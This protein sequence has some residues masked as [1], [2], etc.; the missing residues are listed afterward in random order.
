MVSS[1]HTAP[2]L[3]QSSFS[4]SHIYLQLGIYL[5]GFLLLIALHLLASYLIEKLNQQTINEQ[6]RLRIGEII[7]TDLIRIESSAYQMATLRS[8]RGQTVVRRAIS[9]QI[10]ELRNA[11]QILEQGGTLKRVTELNIESHERM[12]KTV[13]Y[14]PIKRDSRYVLEVID[15]LPKLDQ[16]ELMMDELA[17]RLRNRNRQ[18]DSP[19]REDYVK[20]TLRTKDYLLT[21][22]PLFTRMKENA[23]RLFFESQQRLMQLEKDISTRK[24][25]YGLIEWLLVAFIIF[26]VLI[27]G[28]LMQRQIARANHRLQQITEQMIIA[29]HE[30][31]AANQA[32]SNFLAN[33]SHEIRT[34]MNGVVGMLQLLSK[35]ELDERQHHYV[36]TALRSA[37]LQTTIINDILDF[38]K[39]EADRLALESIKFDLYE[40]VEE[41]ATIL[42]DG[43]YDKGV[44]L[45]TFIDPALPQFIQGDPTRLRQLLVNLI[46]NAI[47]F[48]FVGEINV[49]VQK[50]HERTI[51][52]QIIDTGIGMESETRQRLFQPFTQAD[53]STTRRFGGT[54]LGLAISYQLVKAM[55][56]RIGVESTL[57]QG[58]TFWFSVPLIPAVQDRSI[59]AVDLTQHRMLVVDD[60]ATNREVISS[61]LDAWKVA[62]CCVANPADALAIY[63]EGKEKQ[64]NFSIVLLDMH[65]P[66]MDGLALAKRLREEATDAPLHLLL[67]TS[68]L[69][70]ES[71]ELKAVGI[72][73]GITKPVGPSRLLDALGTLLHTA[74]IS[75]TKPQQEY[76]PLH[77]H[78]LVVEDNYVN[79][80]VALGMLRQLGVTSEIANDGQEALQRLAAGELEQRRWDLILMDLQM[81]RM[82]GYTAARNIRQLEQNLGLPPV[83]IAALTANATTEDRNKVL[84]AEM[85]A[86]L[87]K[88]IK[89]DA[90]YHLLFQWL[91]P[92][93]IAVDKPSS[94]ADNATEQNSIETNIQHLT[95][96]VGLTNIEIHNI[97]KDFIGKFGDIERDLQYLL[98]TDIDAAHHLIHTLKGV[99]GNLGFDTVFS[100]S[101]HLIEVIQQRQNQLYHAQ[102]AEL[103]SVLNPVIESIAN[104]LT[105]QQSSSQ[106]GLPFLDDEQ[107]Q[108]H[109]QQ[110]IEP[111][112]RH[113]ATRCREMI[114]ELSQYQLAENEMPFFQRLHQ[115]IY[116]HQYKKALQMLQEYF[117]EP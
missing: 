116:S 66:Q 93:P 31:E 40:T 73:L 109:Y 47:K 48:T 63:R 7:I 17:E 36:N 81:P 82:D 91:Q 90:L 100:A 38:S 86:H 45:T 78:V 102:L 114:S 50:E 56:G 33:M 96:E 60:N 32:K 77:G 5:T 8:V 14:E 11:L 92:S 58:S 79:R 103:T 25:L 29:R 76:Q 68:G 42:A 75:T 4:A 62:H 15:L 97:F 115:T 70:P 107:L 87:P 99:A 113:D 110:L 101:Q 44:E 59:P 111:L 26:L 2:L 21:L 85:N 1:D 74:S 71:A 37:N 3:P 22:P 104:W 94:V 84:A 51:L 83:P 72:D 34:P 54:G 6:A 39:I 65:L 18:W 80:E 98:K 64:S 24:K 9:Q 35:T 16:V 28:F 88:P 52:F 57:G 49:R 20:A 117:D 43:A 23:N 19:N 95:Q 67:L 55:D 61:Y 112:G 69:Q 108:T 12:I 30:A 105:Q 13:S 46:G 41:V 89:L 106:E 27:L 53:E 10:D